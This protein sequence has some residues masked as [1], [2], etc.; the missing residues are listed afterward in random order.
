MTGHKITYKYF[1]SF[2]VN[3]THFHHRTKQ[4]DFTTMS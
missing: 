2:Q 3:V 4:I 1:E